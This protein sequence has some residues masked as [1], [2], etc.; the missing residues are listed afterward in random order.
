MTERHWLVIGLAAGL[1][2]VALGVVERSGAPLAAGA[3]ATVNGSAIGADDLDRALNALSERRDITPDLAQQ[4]LDRLIDEELLIQR[5]VEL[6][7]PSRDPSLRTALSGAVIDLIVAEAE[8]A[9]TVVSEQELTEF[10]A[11]NRAYF[12]PTPRLKV[13]A[14]TFASEALAAS[15]REAGDLA[16]GA[17]L[18]G[19]PTGL[20][21]VPALER[22]VGGKLT[23]RLAALKPGQLS[24]PIARGDRWLLVALEA[25]EH[26]PAPSLHEIRPRVIA[27]YRRRAGDRALRAFLAERR[28]TSRIVFAEP[29]Q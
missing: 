20:V 14:A 13:R 7:L 6:N 15:A 19:V 29:R 24:V 21:P 17:P 22:S 1:A 3:I 2:L 27:E 8:L 10:Y 26:A 28:A 23:A 18:V 12:A 16:R 25:R 9:A 4:V 5:G 11:A